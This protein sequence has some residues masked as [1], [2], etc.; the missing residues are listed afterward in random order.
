MPGIIDLDVSF[1]IIGRQAVFVDVERQILRLDWS[2]VFHT[3][4]YDSDLQ[5][6]TLIIM[7]TTLNVNF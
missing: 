6:L 1:K 2:S 3:P 4:I 7:L 5:L